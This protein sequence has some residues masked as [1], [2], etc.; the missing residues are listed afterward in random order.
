MYD[1]CMKICY[2]FDATNFSMQR[3]Q[4]WIFLS[5]T[6]NVFRIT[7]V[8]F[9]N[10]QHFHLVLEK[11]TWRLSNLKK[12]E[13]TNHLKT[14]NKNATLIKILKLEHI[15]YRNNN[16]VLIDCM[17]HQYSKG[18]TKIYAK[19]KEKLDTKIRLAVAS[20]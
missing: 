13:L 1:A 8:I 11:S 2:L 15:K 9:S 4:Q 7:L 3:Y 17:C 18:Y 16:V 10:H 12:E 20:T 5:S 19:L 6:K 14:Y